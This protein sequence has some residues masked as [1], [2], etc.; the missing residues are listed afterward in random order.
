[1]EMVTVCL[2]RRTQGKVM[3]VDK[4][5]HG[6][7]RM[8]SQCCL[9]LAP[10]INMM[11]VF[12]W[13][14]TDTWSPGVKP[15]TCSEHDAILMPKAFLHTAENVPRHDCGVWHGADTY[16]Q[17]VA[18]AVILI[19][20]TASRNKDALCACRNSR[21]Q[22]WNQQLLN[23]FCMVGTLKGFLCLLA[24]ADIGNRQYDFLQITIIITFIITF[25]IILLLSPLSPSSPSGTEAQ[26]GEQQS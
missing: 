1:M 18:G 11:Q 7:Y 12:Y 15:V 16:S 23:T 19:G 4:D 13:I 10:V 26:R 24:Q 3:V 22:T 17:K 14:I 8:A 20:P 9:K 2:T 25:I 5:H 21:E 6:S